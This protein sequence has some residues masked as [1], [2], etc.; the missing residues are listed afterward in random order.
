MDVRELAGP[1]VE[2]TAPTTEFSAPLGIEMEGVNE[3][4]TA[5]L[6][7]R[8]GMDVREL[9][10]PVAEITAPTIEFSAPLGI[11]IEEITA[12]TIEFSAPLGI[13]MEVVNEELT[14]PLA[15]VD[16]MDV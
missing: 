9:A 8:E 11:E 2:I 1:L 15:P 13:E 14:V 7:P 16:G 4:L 3:E 5:P 6:A 10:G 12:P